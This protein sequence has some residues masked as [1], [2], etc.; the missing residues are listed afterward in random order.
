MFKMR[1]LMEEIRWICSLE[2]WREKMKVDMQ[3]SLVEEDLVWQGP[4]PIRSKDRMDMMIPK[5]DGEMV[6]LVV[7]HMKHTQRNYVR[8]KKGF[9]LNIIVTF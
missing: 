5:S 6:D 7:V 1:L 8:D 9:L 3:D 2:E 4:D